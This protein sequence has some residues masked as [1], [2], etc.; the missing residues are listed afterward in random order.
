[1]NKAAMLH[2]KLVK[3]LLQSVY[4]T[5]DVLTLLNLLA[6][7]THFTRSWLAF[8]RAAVS[9]C[10]ARAFDDE[11]YPPCSYP[12][13]LHATKLAMLAAISAKSVGA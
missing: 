1:M 4:P 12:A 6:R 9:L 7:T 8:V 5:K 10:A 3:H 11:H 2:H 13:L